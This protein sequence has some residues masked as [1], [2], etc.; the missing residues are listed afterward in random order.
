[1]ASM[2]RTYLPLREK[3]D[4]DG[5]ESDGVDY[6]VIVIG[7]GIMG[8]CTSWFLS[9]QGRKVLLLEQFPLPHSRGSSHGHSRIIRTAYSEEHFNK[10]MPDAFQMW[11]DLEKKSGESLILNTGLLCISRPPCHEAEL[12]LDNMLK[13]K[14][15]DTE[16]LESQTFERKFPMLKYQNNHSVFFD[17]SGGVILADRA[18]RAVQTL[19]KQAG[20]ILL[21][22][23]PVVNIWPGA[24]ATVVTNKGSF[25]ASSVVV[26]AGS[27]TNKVL[28]HLELA[29]P[30][31]PLRIS[32]CYWREKEAYR[33][34]YSA[35]KGFPCFIDYNYHSLNHVY[36]LPSLEYPGLAKICLHDSEECDAD[37][38]DWNSKK[39]DLEIISN[40]IKEH[41]PG[42][43]YSPAIV[44]TC[45][46]T[47]CCL[48]TG[49]KMAPV[50]GKILG[51]MVLDI[52]PSHDLT[53]FCISRFALT[54]VIK[55]QL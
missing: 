34:Q 42:L 41:C 39:W 38:R 47:Y 45:I 13:I 4:F 44:E 43:D 19:F 16:V 11:K 54:K 40:F 29:L 7:A 24:I 21:D 5:E 51:E 23:S 1:M 12:A 28:H 18:L 10:M 27:W 53:P 30:L 55:S 17:K 48:G 31:K 15:E 22:S 49:F 20:G 50:I 46:Y 2:L 37:Q 8:S 33:G 52:L 35:H 26:C 25:R 36:G 32:T 14:P 6:D 9:S 3:G